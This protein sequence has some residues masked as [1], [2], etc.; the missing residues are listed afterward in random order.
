M[1]GK[2]I[3]FNPAFTNVFGWTLDKRLGKKMDVFV[4][5][6]TWPETNMMID[7]VMTGEMFSGIETRRYTKEGKIIPVSISAAFYRDRNGKPMGSV[8]NLRDIREQKQ[9][10]EQLA[11]SERLAATGQLAA[12]I[13]HEINSPL[14]AV[15]ILVDMMKSKY[16]K[17]GRPLEEIELLGEA[18][19]NIR[20]TVQNLLDLS[21]PGKEE[22]QPADVNEI[23][24]KTFKLVRSHL[25]KNKVKVNLDLTPNV[26]IITASPQQLSQVFLNLINNSVEA[27][28]GE[29][30]IRSNREKRASIGGEI[31]VKTNLEKGDIVI[32]VSDTGPGFLEE[33][34]GHIFDHFFTGKK[35]MGMGVG[36]SV[37]HGIIENHNGTITARNSPEGWAVFTITLPVA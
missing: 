13:A 6:E 24:D 23:I 33:D 9:I 21:H 19:V 15:T 20:D 26:P 31:F 8:I 29:S 25:K 5:E 17:E 4:P 28:S 32:E 12:S 1:E 2:V 11:R 16:R 3:Y 27:M 34:L 18:F 37:C 35:K 30:G 36:L 22:K 14:Q 7:K 10:Q